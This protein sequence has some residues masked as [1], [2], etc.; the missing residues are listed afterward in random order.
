MVNVFNDV[1]VIK[2]IVKL[3]DYVKHGSP[4]LIVSVHP[5]N[6]AFSDFFDPRRRR[7]TPA[8]EKF[9]RPCLEPKSTISG[10]TLVKSKQVPLPAL[11]G[12]GSA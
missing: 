1:L 4:Y 7:T 2:S 12:G 8:V 6:T 11:K 9:L 5:N 3:G 10:W